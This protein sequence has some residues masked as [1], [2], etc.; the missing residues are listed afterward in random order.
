[1]LVLFAV[2]TG[3]LG[4]RLAAQL[5]ARGGLRLLP[6][7][8]P[9]AAGGVARAHRCRQPQSRRPP[10][11]DRRR[12]QLQHDRR[13]QPAHARH[14]EQQ[15]LLLRPARSRG[16]SATSHALQARAIVNR[17]NGAVADDRARG[18]GVRDHAA[19]DSRPR[20]VRAASRCGCRIAA[21]ARSSSST[22]SCRS[23]WPQRASGPSSPA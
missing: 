7:E 8:R 2:A 13:L 14:R 9:A 4:N 20:Q 21:A 22:S 18:G 23:S 16:T 12:R 17:L 15:R 11:Q 10:G 6:A 3:V 1:M 19:V 5:P